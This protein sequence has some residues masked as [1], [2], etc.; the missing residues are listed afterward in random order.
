[1]L[2]NANKNIAL[3]EDHHEALK[4]WREKGIKNLTL[5]H[6]DAH[7]DF[8]FHFAKP[9]TQAINE[10]KSLKDLKESLER[11][12]AFSRYERDF[13]KQTNIGNYIY[14]AMRDGII[15]DFYWVIPGGI[16]EFEQSRK[17]L[18]V[19]VRNLLKQDPFRL[20]QGSGERRQKN[21]KS[22]TNAINASLMGRGFV[23]TTLEHLPLF[24]DKVLLDID[25]DFLVV[26]GLKNSGATS[27]IGK[28]KLWIQPKEFV[29]I[30]REKIKNP[31][32]TTIAYSV[33]GGFTPM[34]YKHLGDEIA[35]Y[36]APQHFDRLFKRK[37]K[38]AE[39][40]NLFE[41][42]GKKKHYTQAVCLNPSYKAEYNNYGPLYLKMGEL[43]KAEKEFKNIKKVDPRNPYA[44]R[45]IADVYLLKKDYHQAKKYFKYALQEKKNLDTAILGLAHAELKLNNFE[46]AKKLLKKYQ[47]FKPMQGV[48]YRLLGDIYW[49]EK[50]FQK[51][52]ILYKSAIL[53]GDYDIINIL[54][55]LLRISEHIT[56]KNDIIKYV[57]KIYAGFKKSF[58]R[59]AKA[60]I[61]MQELKK[62]LN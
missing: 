50:K 29:N 12:L 13:K 25:T 35:Y 1:M 44:L 45:G 3:I 28:R 60:K 4:L 8:Y 42:T 23:I 49:K 7:L 27:M 48:S 17:W 41:A 15:R 20:G 51:A 10:A 22:P 5:I 56:E 62:Q 37:I 31:E 33:N 46:K 9:P 54:L 38:A 14:P 32:F 16:R 24:N 19:L 40:F 26:D 59:S 39:Y 21:S 61:K 11:T 18:K 55:K 57:A 6:I 2:I 43:S 58:Y 36:L 34:K 52:A 53:L 30:L 47:T